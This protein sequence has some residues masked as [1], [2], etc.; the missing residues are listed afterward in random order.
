[1][2]HLL[3]GDSLTEQDKQA[4]KNNDT[5]AYLLNNNYELSQNNHIQSVEV[6]DIRKK[7]AILLVKLYVKVLT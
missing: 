1:M 7:K 3:N 6:K 5:R 4:F 2:L